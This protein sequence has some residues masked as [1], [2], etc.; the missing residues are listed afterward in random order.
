M[1]KLPEGVPELFRKALT[2]YDLKID[3]LRDNVD[4]IG[5]FIEQ[6][7]KPALLERDKAIARAAF[8]EGRQRKTMLVQSQYGELV[9]VIEGRGLTNCYMKDQT[10][11]D[12]LESEEFKKLVGEM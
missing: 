12:Y 2:D 9:R 7:L 6:E 11:D 10:A 5:Q 1:S 8:E 3:G 4:Y